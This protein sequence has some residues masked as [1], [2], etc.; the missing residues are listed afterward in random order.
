MTTRVLV[1]DDDFMVARIHERFVERTDGYEVVGS[2]RTGA[3]A[4]EAV[5]TLQ[6]DLVLLDVHM[7]DVDGLEV[8]RRVRAAGHAVGVV[9]V[10]AERDAEVVRAALLGGAQQYLV[11]PFEY[12]DLVARLEA[13]RRTLDALADRPEDVDQAA[14]DAAFGT[15]GPAA[16]AVLPKG[17]SPETA[18]RVLA[19]LAD[20]TERS[21]AETGDEVGIA[22]VSARRYLEHF[23]TTGRLRVRLQY[24]SA[25]RPERRYSVV[26][27]GERR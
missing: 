21:A 10:T 6:P 5:E 26:A 1:V 7:P 23:V 3:E 19:T 22:R 2:V 11:K 16:P 15:G 14:I 12:P 8:L 24:G 20:G 13:V 27:R 9:M 25:G 17:L 4:V 18:E